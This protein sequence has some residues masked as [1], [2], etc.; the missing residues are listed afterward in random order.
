MKKILIPLIMG[1]ISGHLSY[2]AIEDQNKLLGI[3]ALIIAF[4]FGIYIGCD[5]GKVYI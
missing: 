4:G 1:T 3:I 5:Y 2:I